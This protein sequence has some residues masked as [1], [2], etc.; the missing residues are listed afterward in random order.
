[1][2]SSRTHGRR[3]SPTRRS[4][5]GDRGRERTVLGLVQEHL[6]VEVPDPGFE[7]GWAE[8]A[9]EGEAAVRAGVDGEPEHLLGVV[10]AD[11]GWH[12]W[13]AQQGGGCP[14][15]TEAPV[16]AHL[17]PE[18]GDVLVGRGGLLDDPED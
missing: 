2:L 9:S 16:I 6:V 8:A 4:S 5:L 17:R 18:P 10:L 11:V 1:M 3:L 7:A 14:A 12:A 15:G 13:L